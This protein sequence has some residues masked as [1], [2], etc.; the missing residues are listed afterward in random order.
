MI[1]DFLA[2]SKKYEK[3]LVA[4][5]CLAIRTHG[6]TRFLCYVRHEIWLLTI[7]W[8]SVEKVRVSLKSDKNK[9]I[10]YKDTHMSVWYLPQFSL[11]LEIFRTKVVKK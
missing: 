11:E 6:T 3:R 9:K 7:F 5:P 10:F 8:K 2:R 4:S 1:Y